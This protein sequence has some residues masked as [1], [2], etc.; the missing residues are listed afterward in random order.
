M[1][2]FLVWRA[3]DGGTTNRQHV[4]ADRENSL[5]SD[6]LTRCA[7]ELLP[8]PSPR[9]VR[10]QRTSSEPLIYLAYSSCPHEVTQSHPP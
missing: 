2:A 8:L 3:H 4:R 10:S 9:Y 6:I 5:D 7:I 1:T